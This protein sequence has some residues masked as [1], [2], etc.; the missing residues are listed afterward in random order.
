MSGR[1]YTHHIHTVNN[2][3]AI[4]HH[5][6][7][8]GKTQ[9]TYLVALIY[10]LGVGAYV[11]KRSADTDVFIAHQTN[12]NVLADA[13]ITSMRKYFLPQ[14]EDMQRQALAHSLPTLT[15]DCP[16]GTL[17]IT[18]NH[19]SQDHL[20]NDAAFTAAIFADEGTGSMENYF[21]MVGISA[22]VKLCHG[23]F[24][25]WDAANLWHGTSRNNKKG[26]VDRYAGVVVMSERLVQRWCQCN[27]SNMQQRTKKTYSHRKKKG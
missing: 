16:A 4:W 2:W 23:L 10:A 6:H 1:V 14:L 27:N 7:G 19:A 8:N 24:G 25:C 20:D 22:Y 9:F 13:I 21:V 3:Q 17:I 18:G 12:L 26:V 5:Y 11:P 15:D